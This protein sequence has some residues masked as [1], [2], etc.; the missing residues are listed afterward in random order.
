MR[1]RDLSIITTILFNFNCLA[2]SIE[3]LT[4]DQKI[5][6]YKAY[7]V[8]PITEENLNKKRNMSLVVVKDQFN[9]FKTSYQGDYITDIGH[10]ILEDFKSASALEMAIVL[11]D[12]KAVELLI[13]NSATNINDNGTLGLLPI[14]WAVTLNEFEIFQ[15]IIANPKFNL[16]ALDEYNQTLLHTIAHFSGNYYHTN[17][18]DRYLEAVLKLEDKLDLNIQDDKGNTPLHSALYAGNVDFYTY[19]VTNAKDAVLEVDYRVQNNKGESY[20]HSTILLDDVDFFKSEF[21]KEHYN[22]NLKE[23]FGMTPLHFAILNS[24]SCATYLDTIFKN[25]ETNANIKDNKGRNFLNIIDI[26]DEEEVNSRIN[27]I[28][29]SNKKFKPNA[30]EKEKRVVNLFFKR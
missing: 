15:S 14:Q 8:V 18:T 30:G 12:I 4:S 22:T 29:A 2:S 3:N 27:Y 11:G 5:A 9:Y 25:K 24:S 16:S 28:I 26:L 1:I 10:D 7:R 23:H 20:L 21:I 19:L 6:I 17:N 13:S